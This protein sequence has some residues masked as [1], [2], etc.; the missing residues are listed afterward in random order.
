MVGL[1]R[2]I[3]RNDQ[4][5]NQLVA[6]FVRGIDYLP[7]Q[8]HG[9]IRQSK[10]VALIFAVLLIISVRANAQ[11]VDVWDDNF[12]FPGV[13]SGTGG[14][15]ALGIWDGGSGPALVVSGDLG[16]VGGVSV[17]NIAAWN[18][19]SWEGI[20]AG[21]NSTGYA[22]AMAVHDDGSGMALYV[23]GTFI[24]AGGVAA[25]RIAR[26]NGANWSF[27]GP[28]L[29]GI[30]RSLAVYD[31]GEG[32][33][34]YAGGDFIT[35]GALTV[36]RIAK[37]DGATWSALGAGLSESVFSLVVHD[38][39]TGAALYAAGEF[40]DAG[41]NP[42]ADRIAK[43]D[44]SS[45]TALGTGLGNDVNVLAVFDDGSGPALF[46]GGAFVNAGGDV[47]A[48]R[49]AKWTGSNWLALGSGLSNTVTTLAAFDDGS[50]P[51]L[52][53]GG[54]FSGR[55]VKW[56]GATWSQLGLG[57]GAAVFRAVPFN[58]GS[59]TSLFASGSFT[60][61]DG[62]VMYDLASWNG[63]A[64]NSVPMTALG[65]SPPN[66]SLTSMAQFD[67]GNGPRIYVSGGLQS[68]GTTAAT[69]I[70]R[71]VGTTWEPLGSGLNNVAYAMAGYD[72]GGGPGLFVGG[73][74]TTAGGITV[75]RIAK[76]QSGVWSNLG[77]AS[78]T[79]AAF[80][81]HDDGSGP[82]LFV[83]GAFTT[84]GG[85]SANR[86]AKLTG[87][88]W[89]PV[90]TGMNSSVQ[91]LIVYDDGNGEALY[92]AGGFTTAD[93][94]VANRVAKWNGTNW[95]QVGLGTND[96]IY[97]LAVHDDGSGTALFAGGE[98]TNAG[99]SSAARVA[100]WDGMS[101]T[102]LA[103]GVNNDVFALASHGSGPDS[104]LYVG[105]QFTAAGGTTAN[106]IA[107]WRN[108]QWDPVGNGVEGVQVASLLS[109]EG[110]SGPELWVGGYYWTAGGKAASQVTR[111]TCTFSD[112]NKNGIDDSV[113]IGAGTSEDC[114]NNDVPDECDGPDCNVNDVLDVCDI[115]AG[116]SRDCNGNGVPEECELVDCNLNTISD[117]CDVLDATSLDCDTN[118]RPDECDTCLFPPVGGTVFLSGDDADDVGHCFG[119]GC[120]GLYPAIFSFAVANSASP[121]S[122]ILALG[123]NGGQ[124]LASLNSW[125]AAANGGPDVPITVMTNPLDIQTVK[126]ADYDVVY[127]PSSG[128]H[129]HG[130][131]T[132]MQL[133]AINIRQAAMADFVNVFGGSLIALTQA[134]E[135]EAYGWL[136]IPV[137]TQ[138]RTH[139][140]VCPT[141]SLTSAL[142]PGST[143][144]NMSHCCYHTVFTGPPGFLGLSVLA[145]STDNPVGDV[146]LLGGTA[147]GLC[148]PDC[149]SN[150]VPDECE[151]ASGDCNGNQYLD[152]CESTEDCNENGL[153]DVCDIGAGSSDDCDSDSIPD[154]C[155]SDCNQN[156]INDVCELLHHESDEC[157]SALLVCPGLVVHASTNE[158]SNDGSA[159]C[160]SAP[161]GGDVWYKYQ[162]AA[163]GILSVS[164]CGSTFDTVLS[165]HSNCPGS[166]AELACNDN[167]CGLQ[168]SL[169]MN[170]TAGTEYFVRVAGN[171]SSVGAFD[172]L[173][174]GP[175]CLEMPASDCNVNAVLDEC[176]LANETSFDLNSNGIP[177]ECESTSV[178]AV[179]SWGMLILFLLVLCFGSIVMRS[180]A[181]H[182]SA[183]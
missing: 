55:M 48:D 135:P 101:W 89:S 12:A 4:S 124:A 168:A 24:T 123:I 61:V 115:A 174:D 39:G 10:C 75:N 16:I 33:A 157:G 28:G 66:L 57:V 59:G 120:G 125:N 18:G 141:T 90:G 109:V 60:Q 42:N 172:L 77:G 76:W 71:F 142:S 155:Q 169:A 35:A 126:L 149:N 80:A 144:Q 146:I 11:C 147:Q 100:K 108:G 164:L 165:I 176:D 68:A 127:I 163:S 129:T 133:S 166:G 96:W 46:A 117:S 156:N 182:V 175:P 7:S 154:E 93:G 29:Q 64:W 118:G 92:A 87:T 43:W 170:V 162:P 3:K 34:L 78:S 70:A 183:G 6:L 31:D 128:I 159:S 121:G 140:S 134:D 104:A 37:W 30:V 52:H 110:K 50:G 36:N 84:I 158:A 160:E 45:W 85:I 51:A 173:L 79:V 106:R 26:W 74:F 22:F 9:R 53:A 44:G 112:C 131:F 82:A 130:G 17:G 132:A 143:C 179:S 178:P 181:N 13:S 58:D 73:A 49:I 63:A 138:D 139:V 148:T 67:D 88:T 114:N 54:E 25:D 180:R 151:L 97:A 21:F 153:P 103:T 47:N 41:G 177:D 136:P 91:A 113:D 150:G 99:G 95:S 19:S 27:L 83:G 1:K 105:G 167:A 56:N 5:Q 161:G 119:T 23:G 8:R 111:L 107:K 122:G 15:Y 38:D 81:V 145:E 94:L 137:L 72:D 2:T 69:R 20:G 102:A 14:T 116:T 152:A 171:G 86:I 65:L 32:S 98:F 40:T 62:R